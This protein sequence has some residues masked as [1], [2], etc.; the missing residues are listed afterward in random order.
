MKK[1]CHLSYSNR[2]RLLLDRLNIVALRHIRFHV[3][4]HEHRVWIPGG[5][6]SISEKGQMPSCCSGGL[7]PGEVTDTFNATNASPVFTEDLE[8]ALVSLG[9]GKL[10]A[11]RDHLGDQYGIGTLMKWMSFGPLESFGPT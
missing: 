8:E 4:S 3:F 10:W 6:N 5:R 1:Y 7:P 9:D 2:P 11:H